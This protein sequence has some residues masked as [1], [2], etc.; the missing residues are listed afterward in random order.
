MKIERVE[1]L[2]VAPKV[3]RFTWS[4]DLPEQ[5]M[6]NTLVRV[7]TDDGVEGVGGVSNYTSFDF[8]R[9]TAETMR[10]MIPALIGKDPL[11]REQIWNALWS[12]VFPL[13]H[14][15]GIEFFRMQVNVSESRLPP[16]ITQT[17]FPLP[18][19]PV[20][21]AATEEAPAPSA[22]TRCRSTS[23]RMAPAISSRDTTIESSIRLFTNGQIFSK[24]LLPPIPS[25]KLGV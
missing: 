20:R 24:T 7:Y 21:A 4:H 10:H 19:R 15:R 17:I 3:Q 25:T 9:Y 8:D 12:R 5:Y 6:T 11:Q 16:E 2:A 23:S 1:V 18:A 14:G 13:D 22:M